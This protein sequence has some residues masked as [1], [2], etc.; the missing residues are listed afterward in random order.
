MKISKILSMCQVPDQNK[1]LEKERVSILVTSH[2]E[3]L[4]SIGRLELDL[5]S[6]ANIIAI[7]GGMEFCTELGLSPI[8]YV[9]D[10]DS[11]TT[12]IPIG[13]TVLPKEKDISDTE[14]GIVLAK[15]IKS[16]YLIIVGGQGGRFDHSF[17]NLCLLNKYGSHF[18]D[19]VM[20]D[21]QNIIRLLSPGTYNI[22]NTSHPYVGLL[23]FS[24]ATSG[25]TLTGFKYPLSD[26]TMTNAMNRGISNEILGEKAT[27]SFRS[28][29]LLLIYSRD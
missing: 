24:E 25:L 16:S 8:Y 5:P 27:I 4:S 26:F 18:H 23:S 10:Y 15:S 6:Y 13:A 3:R 2:I 1:A 29:K 14:A 7:D 22:R 9:G 19:M 21:G 11:A 12:Q 17:G 28:G 20:V